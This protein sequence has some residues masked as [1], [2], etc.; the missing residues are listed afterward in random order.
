MK[1]IKLFSV[2]T[3]FCF[4]AFLTKSNAQVDVTINPI[5]ILFGNMNV[6]AD[7]GITEN[8]SLEASVGYFSRKSGGYKFTAFPLIAT[9]KYYFNPDKGCDKFYADV[10][11]KYFTWNFKDKDNSGLDEYSQTRFGGGFGIGYKIVSQK[12]FVFDI[13]GGIGRAIVDKVKYEDGSNNVDEVDVVNVMGNF[14]LGI[15]Y[16]FGGK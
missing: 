10:F 13:G 7:F 11:L 2:I 15:G 5:G 8:I 3:F 1:A 12:G 4:G 14:K 16:R 6:G 9:G